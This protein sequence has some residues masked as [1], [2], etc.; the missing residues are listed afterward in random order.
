MPLLSSKVTPA[1]T[2]LHEEG[3]HKSNQAVR[4]M[5]MF[6]V[7]LHTLFKRYGGQRHPKIEPYEDFRDR[8]ELILWKYIP[9]D[10]KIIYI[11]HEW[12]GTNYPDPKGDQMYHLLLLLERLQRGDVVRTDMDAFH[13]ILYKHNYTT[14]A[15][16]WKSILDPQNTF[17]F[18]D[19]FCI[20]SEEREEAFR[21][22]P[23]CVK[24]CD[25][26][27]IL[28]PG[29]THFDKVDTPQEEVTWRL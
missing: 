22:V 8:G 14:T 9:P 25:F 7:S 4:D 23:E 24:R 26:M 21:M 27:I 6:V 17:V 15:E 20:P 2:H 19:G 29:C 3:Q 12:A 5:K 28:A 10:S 11:S 18:Y 1:N 16:E 13:S